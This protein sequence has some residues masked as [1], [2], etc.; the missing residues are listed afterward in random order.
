VLFV[1][2]ILIVI[3]L[4]LLALESE[5]LANVRCHSDYDPCLYQPNQGFCL[6]WL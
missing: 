5:M 3:L 6:R 2:F 1:A 4:L